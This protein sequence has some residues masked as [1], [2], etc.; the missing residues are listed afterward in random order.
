MV[1]RV[2]NLWRERDILERRT[3]KIEIKLKRETSSMNLYRY[4]IFVASLQ[5]IVLSNNNDDDDDD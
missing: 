2:N 5:L 1:K 3:I 4:G